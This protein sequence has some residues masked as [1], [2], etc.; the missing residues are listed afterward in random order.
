MFDDSFRLSRDYFTVLE[1]LRVAGDWIEDSKSDWN[2]LRE[3]WTR[4]VEPARWFDKQDLQKAESFWD[5]VTNEFLYRASRLSGRI[6]RKVA[7]VKSLRDGVSQ[8]GVLKIVTSFRYI[9]YPMQLFSATSLK[10][11]TKG[12]ALNRA[13]YVFTVVTVI[14]TPISFLAVGSMDLRSPVRIQLT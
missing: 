8:T 5:N 6:E 11:A 10:E 4:R 9:N 3:D 13:V 7:E 2:H 14:Y 1:A 12:I